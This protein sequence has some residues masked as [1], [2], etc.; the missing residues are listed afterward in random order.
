MAAEERGKKFIYRTSSSFVKVR[1]GVDDMPLLTRSEVKLVA[2]GATC[3]M[4]SFPAT[5]GTARRS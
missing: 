5:S 2:K 3:P 4:S 1:G